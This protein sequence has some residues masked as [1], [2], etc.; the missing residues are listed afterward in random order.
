MSQS[1]ISREK[2]RAQQRVSDFSRQDVKDW[3]RFTDHTAR[4]SF[5]KQLGSDPLTDEKLL[6]YADSMNRLKTGTPVARVTGD[7]G[8][9]YSI[10]KL[11][12][13]DR[14]GCTCNDWRYVRSV[15]ESPDAYDCKHIKQY[16]QMSKTA[17][18]TYE[19]EGSFTHDGKRYSL[20]EAFRSAR[21]QP[22]KQIP[23]DDLKWVLAYDRPDPARLAAADLTAPVLV[24]PDQQG[25]PTVVDGLHRLSKAVREGRKTIPAKVL[26]L[27]ALKT[28]AASFKDTL[29]KPVIDGKPH[30][31]AWTIV[32]SGRL[33]IPKK[34]SD[35]DY[36]VPL[37]EVKDLSSFQEYK[38]VPG[39]YWRD[40]ETIDGRPST[41]VALPRYAYDK[42]DA[43]YQQAT[44]RFGKRKLR[45]LKKTLPKDSFYKDIG[46]VYTIDA[47][48]KEGA[49]LISPLKPHQERVLKRLESSDGVIVAHRVGAGKTLTAIAAAVKSGK[50]IEVVTP[51]S[52]TPNFEK[53]LKKHVRGEVD[54]RIRSY[55]MVTKATK[56]GQGVDPQRFL[57]LD[58][59]HRLR[60]S[61]TDTAAAIRP[62]AAKAHKRLLL[63]G[64]AIYNQ[65]AD[66]APLANIAA[67]S[68]VLPQD[69]A[70][71]NARFIRETE[72][73][74]GL[75]QRLRG[76][77]PGI[78]KNLQNQSELENALRGR[79]DLHDEASI[80][81]FPVQIDERV[82]V[83][84]SA[85][86]K[87]VYDTL[88]DAA[89]LHVRLKIKSGL[90]P[91]KQ[92]AKNLNAFVTGTRQASLSPRPYSTGMTDK[93][94][95]QNTP[96]IQEAARRLAQMRA[97]DERFRGVVYSNYI[98]AGLRPYEKALQRQKI[99]F[100]TLT[101]SLS[102]KQKA[103]LVSNYNSGKTPVLLV[104]SSGTEG[105]DLKGTKLVQVLEPHWNNSKIDQVIGRGVRYQSHSHLPEEER[106]VLVQRFYSSLPKSGLKKLLNMDP[107]KSTEEWVQD[108][109]DEKSQLAAEMREM[110]LRASGNE[111]SAGH[112]EDRIAERAPGAES[113]VMTL[114]S[115][116]RK[117]Q[118]RKGQTYHVPLL[119][120]KGYAVI[121]DVGDHHTVKT[122]L[123]PNM[124][125]PDE[126]LKVARAPRDYAKEYAQYHSKPEQVA[127]RS[128]R[129]QA[130]RKLG[131][132]KGDPREAD[133]KTPLSRG[134]GNSHRNLRA[135]SRTTNR[136]KFNK[137]A[138]DRGSPETPAL[139][140]G[141]AAAGLL[142]NL[143][144]KGAG[145]AGLAL[146]KAYGDD[147]SDREL[148][149]LSRK[150]DVRV[151]RGPK[152]FASVSHGITLGG[153]TGNRATF[154]HELGHMRDTGIIDRS[155]LR[156]GS[157]QHTLA[158]LRNESVANLRAIGTGGS[159]ADPTCVRL[160][161]HISCQCSGSASQ[162][163]CRSEPWRRTCGILR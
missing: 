38:D 106:K 88:M 96:K 146:V 152:S 100:E 27:E 33:S 159:S 55:E 58:E 148:R 81:D 85:K 91:S 49:E 52:L 43:S 113:E 119:R 34:T 129:N 1:P 68:T 13:K 101:G 47:M 80:E 37:E 107:G 116:L 22:T 143:P 60:N 76:V 69:E 118:L 79:I 67:G 74:P 149:E 103:R 78:K 51:A 87:E 151:E 18:S 59:A 23:V 46:V 123:G 163:A 71:F 16:R 19:E 162:R 156:K 121:G 153:G 132:S 130:R 150:Y 126:R 66:I 17:A 145:R 128:L 160:A 92:E 120:G 12:G 25:R 63:T 8:R 75:I 102:A 65:P 4:K 61:G 137:V 94:E 140:G 21:T 14:L 135:V 64:T 62:V 158:T 125:P 98:D 10:S 70:A 154:H 109:A 111:K 32:G 127:N 30:D 139:A 35:I 57:I 141:A 41:I 138:E 77:R 157:V 40:S 89:P 84:M 83:P 29:P 56:D 86:Q 131:L 161:G 82:H 104:S 134:G 115:K 3:D 2:T 26:P 122:V 54:A 5:V 90:P 110:F 72:V 36:M 9:T 117:L 6:R 93:D 45:Q 50:P 53:E 95:A 155:N 133:H 142:S 124:R 11:R 44:D 144:Q 24:A 108:R 97:T 31:G 42:I 147:M 99:P 39:V 105:L 136:E 28:A 48:R 15:A 7:G 112:V 20:Q 114:R 73:K